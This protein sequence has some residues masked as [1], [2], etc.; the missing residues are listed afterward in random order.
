ML[1]ILVLVWGGA[2]AFLMPGTPNVGVQLLG[3]AAIFY[4]VRVCARPPHQPLH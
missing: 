1:S 2:V 3:L 4:V